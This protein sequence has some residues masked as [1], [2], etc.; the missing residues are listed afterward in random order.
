MTSSTPK[1]YAQLEK[2]A[3]FYLNPVKIG[4]GAIWPPPPG[5]N[6]FAQHPAGIG[7]TN[8]VP[9]IGPI[10]IMYAERGSCLYIIVG[11][12]SKHAQTFSGLPLRAGI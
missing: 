9:I 10:P 12:I 6:K 7:L 8:R 1:L 2:P 5:R 4:G 3:Y 11:M